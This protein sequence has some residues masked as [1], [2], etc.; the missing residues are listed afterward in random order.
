MGTLLRMP[1]IIYAKICRSSGP[2][3]RFD[4]FFGYVSYVGYDLPNKLQ[5]T[6]FR[7]VA[8]RARVTVRS[9]HSRLTIKVVHYG[10]GVHVA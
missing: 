3:G 10:L 1:V 9:I 5:A 7:D 8:T 6:T 4:D 2:W